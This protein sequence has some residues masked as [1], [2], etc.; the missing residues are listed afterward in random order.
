MLV[1]RLG[2]GAAAKIDEGSGGGLEI[3]AEALLVGSGLADDAFPALAGDLTN[4]IGAGLEP[5]EG[6]AGTIANGFHAL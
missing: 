6:L 4:V 1:E 3:F 5:S 2:V